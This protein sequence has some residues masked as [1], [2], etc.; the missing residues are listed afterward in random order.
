MEAMQSI[1][2]AV[3]R[4]Y[5]VFI[6]RALLDEVSKSLSHQT[7]K[8]LVVH[9]VALTNSAEM[10][11]NSLQEAG[12]ETI[13]A[14]VPD[15][16]DAK[17][18]EVAAF[19]WS[20]LGKADFTRTDAVIGFGGG[21]TTD[22][23]GFVAATWLRGV[24]LIQIPT[25]LLGMVDAAIGGKT[26]INTSEGKN[27]VGVFHSPRA[28]FVDINTLNTLPRNDLLAGFAEIVKY[29][30]IADEKILEII[31]ADIGSATDPQSEMLLELIRRSI[32]IKANVVAA[33]FRESSLREI[34][35]YGHT[36]GHAIELAERY[37]WR[38]GAAISIGM[39]FVAELARIAGRLSDA[40]VDRHK[41]ILTALGLPVSYN[42]EKWPQLLSAMQRDK[43]SRAGSLRFV[44]L[45]AI[46]KPTI[47]TSPTDEM[48]HAAFQEIC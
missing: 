19:C 48:L 31:E 12:F 28:V 40:D 5:E 8:V 41:K 38:H 14:G 21:S 3:D 32:Q 22:L 13:L 42:A 30:F 46:G 1:T 39:V 23:A 33:D 17:R 47:M 25:T 6:G 15:S 18:V 37:K 4:P 10:L 7:R 11:R 20:I 9:P 44:V 27:L 45:D 16:E 34:L 2:V 24:D 29:G 26:G 36:L 43:K 35:N